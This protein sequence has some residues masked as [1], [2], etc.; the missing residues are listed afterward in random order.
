ML[1][2]LLRWL[3]RLVA[4][5]QGESVVSEA[6]AKSGSGIPNNKDNLQ[7]PQTDIASPPKDGANVVRWDWRYNGTRTEVGPP[8]ELARLLLLGWVPEDL[9]IFGDFSLS[10]T[11]IRA[12]PTLTTV[13]GN[14]DLGQCH[15]LKSLG[16][17]LQV[18]GNLR[19]GGKLESE[20][21]LPEELCGYIDRRVPIP[22]LPEHLRI[23]GN[24]ELRDCTEL[25]TL[26]DAM[27]IGRSVILRGCNKLYRLPSNWQINGNLEICGCRALTSLPP[28]L[29]I[30]GDLRLTSTMIHSLPDDLRLDGCLRLVDCAKLRELPPNLHV[31]G[32]L[33]IHRGGLQGLP[34]GLKVGGS[35]RI[36]LAAHLKELPSDLDV[37]GSVVLQRCQLFERFP[38]GVRFGGNLSLHGCTALQELP[39]GLH[40]PGALDLTGC[41]QLTA[42]PAGLRVGNPGQ[43][44]RSV[45]ESKVLR[46]T[47][48]SALSTLPVDLEADAVELTG[49]GVKDIPRKLEK[50]LILISRGVQ[51]PAEVIFHPERLD[52]VQI[53]REPNTE[54][55]RVM[56]ERFGVDEILRR[57]AARVLDHDTDPGGVRQLIEIPA[58]ESLATT[59]MMR[60]SG[61][62]SPAPSVLRFLVC[63]CPSTG[64]Q[65]ILRVPPTTRTCRQ[66]AAWIAGFDNPNSYNPIRET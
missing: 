26:P 37:K 5:P 8:S 31:P 4:V 13:H 49:S 61:R 25:E 19:I 43:R 50:R 51:V 21:Y 53:L 16:Q 34:R 63:R 22:Q 60:T 17:E 33:V 47:G 39:R 6:V 24:L 52:P 23:S 62:R 35:I 56:M 40:V 7:P 66:A 27:S 28:G 1:N 44:P 57:V 10:R 45:R 64:R 9:Q 12:L 3:K 38:E 46:L 20:N 48:C 11:R 36:Y 2:K 41:S 18:H 29:H 30:K 65:Y 14:L 32:A 15:R 58:Q 54:L 42:L 59:V 55:R